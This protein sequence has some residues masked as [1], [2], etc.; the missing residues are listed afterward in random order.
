VPEVFSN[1]AQKVCFYYVKPVRTVVRRYSFTFRQH[2][3]LYVCSAK[4]SENRTDMEIDAG[5]FSFF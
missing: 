4:N 5:I 1:S 3:F 2:S